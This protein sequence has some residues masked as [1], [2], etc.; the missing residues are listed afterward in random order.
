MR[1]SACAHGRAVTAEETGSSGVDG[2]GRERRG[3]S[4]FCDE[5]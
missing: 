4:E 3:L 2:G 5:K 1:R